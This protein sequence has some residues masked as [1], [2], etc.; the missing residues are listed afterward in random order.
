M[1]L[2]SPDDITDM[3]SSWP[4]M[5]LVCA[6]C[7]LALSAGLQTVRADPPPMPRIVDVDDDNAS[8]S[9][10]D[11]ERM[12]QQMK[13]QREALRNDWQ[14]LVKKN[15][16]PAPQMGDQELQMHFKQILK[17]LQQRTQ[18]PLQA[19][20]EPLPS[21]D[22]PRTTDNPPS[23]PAVEPKPIAVE[24]ATEAT[25]PAQ[26]ASAQAN[27]FFR[28]RQY[29]DALAAYRLINLKGQK[30]EVRAPVQYLMAM[31]FLHLGKYDE[32]LPLLREVAN[33]RGDNKL[34][35]YAQWQ[36][37]MIRWQRDVQNRLQDIRQR[38]EA[39]E[40]RL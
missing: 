13:Q 40:K 9:P 10:A 20:P 7:G 17:L 16:R 11:F 1:L 36:L 3:R 15:T 14:S 25:S 24:V 26:N 33:S 39:L 38:R 12:I 30:A 32:A 35:E 4:S 29:E 37:E 18:N 27:A 31:C 5:L 6:A 21:T 22:P 34:A 23:A 2:R 28:L 19:P 8:F